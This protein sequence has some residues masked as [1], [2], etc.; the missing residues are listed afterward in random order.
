MNTRNGRKNGRLVLFGGCQNSIRQT[1]G[2]L[3]LQLTSP[4]IRNKWV[5]GWGFFIFHRLQ[6]RGVPTPRRSRLHGG[7]LACSAP[8]CFDGLAV[9]VGGQTTPLYFNLG[10]VAARPA[11]AVQWKIYPLTYKLTIERRGA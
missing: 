1:N 10:P 9:P 4:Q 3:I 5:G 6:R 2:V 7:A 11:P 8:G